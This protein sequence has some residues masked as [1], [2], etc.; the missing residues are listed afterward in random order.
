MKI[1]GS[2]LVLRRVSEQF[3]SL[4]LRQQLLSVRRAVKTKSTIDNALSNGV[5][6]IGCGAL[7]VEGFCGAV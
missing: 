2:D 6:G 5:V 3:S 4:V 1:G 7:V